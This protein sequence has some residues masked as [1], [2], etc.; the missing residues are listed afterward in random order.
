MEGRIDCR[1]KARR[2]TYVHTGTHTL[3]IYRVESVARLQQ[4]CTAL[5]ADYWQAAE[6]Q[7]ALQHGIAIFCNPRPVQFRCGCRAGLAAMVEG[8]LRT[9]ST[10]R[11]HVRTACH[12][13]IDGQAVLDLRCGNRSIDG[14]P[15]MAR[16]VGEVSESFG[17]WL[18]GL[19][20][21]QARGS[22]GQGLWRGEGICGPFRMN[23]VLADHL[24]AHSTEVRGGRVCRG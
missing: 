22:P 8:R 20:C 9:L 11:V 3:Q 1:L 17:P 23:P 18:M 6:A 21:C 16:M 15:C 5:E 13:L 14:V 4:G 10:A 7:D 19:C 2:G 24:R 12:E